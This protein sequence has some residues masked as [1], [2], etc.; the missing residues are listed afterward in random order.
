M[1]F[2]EHWLRSL[3]NP[4]LSRDE[5]AHLLTMA[6]LEVEE[7]R[8]AAPAFSKVVVARILSA[9]KHP[10]ADKLKLCRVDVGQASLA[11]PLQI[12]CGA[13]NAAVGMRVPCALVGAQLP[14]IS[15]KRAK[16]RGIESFGMLCSARELGLSED[17]GGLLALDDDAPVGQDLREHLQLDDALIDLA[18]QKPQRQ[19]ND[20]RAMRRHPLN[21]KIGLSGIGGTEHGGYPPA[22][23]HGH[24]PVGQMRA[25]H[26]PG[27]GCVLGSFTSSSGRRQ[28]RTGA[29]KSKP[30][31]R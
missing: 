29:R 7:M 9:E 23:L 1:Q 3:V 17:H 8:P 2:S 31:F 13:P 22:V 21:G 5:L 25:H 16:V 30:H 4:P 12:V 6:G 20:A 24:R 28:G 27:C 26:E 15:I 14:G 18:G 11:G 10:D 19:T